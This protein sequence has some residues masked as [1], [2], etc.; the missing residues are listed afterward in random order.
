M[1]KILFSLVLLIALSVFA[2]WFSEN[3]GELSF[4]L[5]GY[6]IE[7][8]VLV[9]LIALVLFVIAILFVSS[10]IRRIVHIPESIKVYLSERKH[11]K[12]IDS[13]SG[14]II[15]MLFEDKNYLTKCAAKLRDYGD[16]AEIK[17]IGAVLSTTTTDLE[18]LSVLKANMQTK[19]GKILAN[20]LIVERY[21]EMQDWAQAYIFLMDS[22]AQQ[23]NKHTFSDILKVTM[24][25]GK[26]SQFESFISKNSS[27]VSRKQYHVL[28]GLTSYYEGKE[29]IAEGEIDAGLFKLLDAMKLLPNFQ[30]ALLLFIETC[31]QHKLKGKLLS[32][33]SNYYPAMQT[34]E[35]TGAILALSDFIPHDQLHTLAMN[36]HKECNESL[37][38]TVLMVQLSLNAGM[39]D[40]AFNAVSKSLSENGK[41]A[42]L[43]LLMAELCQ[44]TQGTTKETIEWIKDALIASNDACNH[45]MYLNVDE[46]SIS[47]LYTPGSIVISA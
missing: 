28:T 15:A 33:I 39:Y 10:L 44:R 17:E 20:N 26:W 12:L 8:T 41:T 32:T 47:P 31:H 24:K 36:I 29:M 35:I 34:P 3:S 5:L 19:E 9:A 16:S 7:T 43:C 46:I 42:R 2:Y 1:F 30:Y 38:S 25:S 37:E 22:W 13:M 6:Q 11:K 40:Q 27:F 45:G 14:S 21:M 4:T 23:K 18:K